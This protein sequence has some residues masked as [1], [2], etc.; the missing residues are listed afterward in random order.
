VF[1]FSPHFSAALFINSS[2][3]QSKLSASPHVKEQILL[4]D[5]AKLEFSWLFEKY[6]GTNFH[7][8]S[9]HVYKWTDWLDE[10]NGHFSQFYAP[11]KKP[12]C[13]NY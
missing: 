3:N 11:N 7:E 12:F 5:L 4:S 10:T 13:V 6:S 8:I 2:D 9:V 1:W